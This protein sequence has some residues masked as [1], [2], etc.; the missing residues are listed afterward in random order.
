MDFLHA[1]K[2]KCTECGV[3]VEV[4][5]NSLIAIGKDG[6]QSTGMRECIACGHCVAACPFDALDNDYT[7]F[8][9]Q[10]PFDDTR[11]DAKTAA[12]FLRSRSS[13]RNYKEEPVP[14]EILLQIL[15]AARFA[16]TGGNSQGLSYWSSAIR[17]CSE[18]CPP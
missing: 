10:I 7:P 5:P 14:R 6:P 12:L 11:I 8:A 15:D 9:N 2:E 3:C 1:D 17:G 13:I 18:G 16:S 4:C